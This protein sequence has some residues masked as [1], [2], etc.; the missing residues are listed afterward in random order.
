M[1]E[2]SN[3]KWFPHYNYLRI[4][5]I[6]LL[7][8]GVFF[9]FVNLDRKVYWDD[10]TTTSLRISGYTMADLS[11]Q[12][13]DGRVISIEDLQKYQHPN[14]EKGL[15]DTIKSLALE[16]PHHPPLYYIMARLWVEWFGSS[17]AIIRSLSA[18][19]SLLV[20]PCIYWLY[21]ELFA[22]P[23]V[24]WVAIVLIAVSPF[25]LLYAQ[26]AREYS[27]WTATIL[28][29]SA[30]L[31]R[32]I[33][34]SKQSH[35]KE[36]KFSWIIYTLTLVLALYSYL[37]SVFTIIG[38]GIYV[39]VTERF[40]LNKTV[41]AFSLASVTGLIAFVP[42]LLVI[43]N[44][45]SNLREGT[46]WL[47][48]NL[49]FLT[50][51]GKWNHNI[52]RIFIDLNL[53]NLDLYLSI[54]ILMVVGYSIYFLFQHTPRQI[55]FFILTTSA[56]PTLALIIPDLIFGGRRSAV[57]RYLIPCYL[58]I[59]LA[60]AF[61]ISTKITSVFANIN[62]Q[63][64]WRIVT[65]AIISSG[66][67]SCVVSSQAQAWW[68]KGAGSIYLKIVPIVNQAA[69]PL[70]I[71]NIY[72]LLPGRHLALSYLLDPKVKLLFVTKEN[73]PKVQISDGFSDIFVFDPF[74]KLK[75][76]I[77]QIQKRKLESLYK[78]STKVWLWR[79]SK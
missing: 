60:V 29:S 45:S 43:I 42:W 3:N 27:L 64:L 9:R 24:G 15:S 5:I 62:Q 32:A 55:W 75:E 39:V 6:I 78:G 47:T 36:A 77:E 8:I 71:S 16:D 26:E 53:D 76:H 34:V 14:P 67:F 61:L 7:I 41:I 13:F 54:P 56:V 4:L 50:L 49:G 58:G 44:S 25:H 79:V 35:S 11:E 52:V 19:I 74:R 18:F 69:H 10:E 1:K 68:N 37:F 22:S 31:L 51:L 70:L 73:I 66:I 48:Q 38:H 23:L 12:A 20:F 59:Q 28:L 63:R 21:L 40:C 17:L 57:E 33:R 65:I 46:E 2:K 72:D 30:A